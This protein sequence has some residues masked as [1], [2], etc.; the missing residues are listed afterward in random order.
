MWNAFCKFKRI[1]ITYSF[2][3]SFDRMLFISEK[4]QKRIFFKKKNYKKILICSTQYENKLKLQFDLNFFYTL[5]NC[6]KID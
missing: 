6:L 1:L 3:L 2:D 5:I 4:T